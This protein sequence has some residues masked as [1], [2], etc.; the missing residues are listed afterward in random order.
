MLVLKKNEN[1]SSFKWSLAR[2]VDLHP[3]Q[4]GRRA[5]AVTVKTKNGIF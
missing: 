1:I 5:R 4:N 3:V 2:V